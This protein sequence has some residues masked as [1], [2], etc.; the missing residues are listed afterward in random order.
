MLIHEALPLFH[1]RAAT[2]RTVMALALLIGAMT[3]GNY[4]DDPIQL[5]TIQPGRR[6]AAGV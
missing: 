1:K 3:Y 5:L 4:R 2:L 6:V